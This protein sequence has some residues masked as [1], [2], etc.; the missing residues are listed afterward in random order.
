MDG[1]FCCLSVD[2]YISVWG[3]GGLIFG[4]A[5]NRRYFLLFIACF[6]ENT[7]S[8]FHFSFLLGFRGIAKLVVLI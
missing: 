1:F 5:Y 3:G 4:A 8:N 2:G 7:E 6:L